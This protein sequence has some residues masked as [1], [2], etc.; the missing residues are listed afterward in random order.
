VKNHRFVTRPKGGK[1][2]ARGQ[3]KKIRQGST[4]AIRMN[5]GKRRGQGSRRNP[6]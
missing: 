3:T 4:R 5:S 1:K 6:F 2:G